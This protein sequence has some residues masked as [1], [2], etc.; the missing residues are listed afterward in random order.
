MAPM[1]VTGMVTDT[2]HKRLRRLFIKEWQDHQKI[3]PET[4]A[5]RLKIERES[6]YRLIRE[7]HRINTVK[8]AELADAMGIEPADF[9]R[10]PTRPSLDALLEKATD[11]VRETAVD[12]VRRLI[13]KAT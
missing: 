2:R 11:D 7:Q 8:L 13:G 1:Y 4:M 5:D 9:Y 12:I 3:G 10:P 6:Y